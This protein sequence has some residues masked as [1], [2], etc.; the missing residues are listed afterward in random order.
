MLPQRYIKTLVVCLTLLSSSAAR[1]QVAAFSSNVTS[2]CAPLLV[3]FNNQS[4][5]ATS[6]Y[7]DFGNLGSS[8][9][10]SPQTTYTTPGTYTVTLIAYNG[11]NSNTITHT[12]TVYDNPVVSFSA[13]PTTVCPGVPV[14]FTNTSTPNTP[15][16]ATYLWDFGDG[17]QSTAQ[18]PSHGYDVGGT[19]NVTLKVT[20]S[21][22]CQ[23]TLVIPSLITVYPKPEA[24]FSA[25]VTSF[26]HAPGV[27]TFTN[28]TT[29][30]APLSY[31][32]LFGDATQSTAASP[33]A[34]SYSSGS[35]TVTLVATDG[36]GCKDSLKMVDYV[37]V[38]SNSGSIGGPTQG[39]AGQVVT[40]T[41]TTPPPVTSSLWDFGDNTTGV[42]ASVSHSYAAAGV[43]TVRLV[44]LAACP[45]TVYKTIDIH[46]KPYIDFNYSP[47]NPCP[48]PD[49]IYFN[50]L[51]VAGSS[52]KWSF[53]D[54]DTSALTNPSHIYNSA[55]PFDV[56]LVA[57]NTY[58]CTDSLTKTA[59]IYL[60]SFD[61]F[62]Y[63]SVMGGCAPVSTTFSYTNAYNNPVISQLWD[64]GDNT[65]TSTLP[66]PS[67]V[68]TNVGTYTV[69]LTVVSA[70]GCTKTTTLTIQAG[71]HSTPMFTASPLNACVHEPITF[72][73]TS[74]NATD[75]TWDFGDGF[76][77]GDS[78]PVHH[79]LYDDT[80]DV[81]LIS[82]NHGC[83][84]TL[85]RPKYILIY[86][87][88]A[89]YQIQY[90]CDTV[91]KVTITN[92]SSPYTSF[93]WSFG[94][95]TT[96]TTDTSPVH[97][98]PGL[99]TFPI[100]L[101]T[102]NSTYGC[103]D[104]L[105]TNARILNPKPDFT[106]GDTTICKGTNSHFVSSIDYQ[107]GPQSSIYNR[108]WTTNNVTQNQHDTVYYNY[109]YPNRGVYD[110]TL[111][112]M[113]EHNCLHSTTKQHYMTVAAPIAGFTAL[114]PTGCLPLTVQFTDTSVDQPGVYDT[115]R[116]WD[117]GYD[118][119]T[120][121][122]ASTS[123]TYT[124][125]GSYYVK[126]TVA[127]NLG[128][129]DS[130]VKYNFI[131]AQKPTASF[132]SPNTY[133]CK[134]DSAHFVNT[135]TGKAPLTS[136]WNFGDNT[137]STATDPVHLYADTGKYTVTLI[138]TDSTGCSDTSVMTQYI[139]VTHPH[140]SFTMNDTLGLCSPMQVNFTSTSS[141][142]TSY[143][144]DFGNT[145]TSVA[146][147]PTNLYVDPGHYTVRYIALNSHGCADTAY[148]SLTLLGYAGA[149]AYSPL[150]GCTP[151]L[152]NFTATTVNIDSMTWDFGDGNVI[153]GG[154][155]MTHVYQVPGTYL[156]LV[157]FGDTAGCHS[158]SLGLDTLRLD[159]L[160]TDFEVS[161][162]SICQ[163]GMAAF[164][165]TQATIATYKWTFDNGETS[166]AAEPAHY[167]GAP[168]TYPV[169][170]IVFTN[171]GCSDTVSKDVTVYPLP[172]IK[173]FG[174]T[175]ICEKDKALLQAEGG[176][177]Y[178]WTPTDNM[179][180]PTCDTTYVRPPRNMTFTVTGTDE[181]GCK[182]DDSVGVTL[183]ECNCIVSLPTAFTPN[184]DGK[185]DRFKV[186][187]T[188]M[189]AVHMEIYNRWGQ[190]VY[191][192]TFTDHSWDGT[193]KGVPC[194]AGTYYYFVKVK[195]IMGQEVMKKGDLELI[196]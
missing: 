125:P 51:T 185:N 119:A 195:C 68:Y 103:K 133:P 1:A 20:N 180:C 84:D 122:T 97:L 39:C 46:P 49:T 5:G 146:A 23:S 65:P 123:Y 34:H 69:T 93:I 182:N 159:G 153:K 169:S 6:Y 21:G 145:N 59:Y 154:T 158:V 137:T 88:T 35:F 99:G 94:D 194:D 91:N 66:S 2:G 82:Y 193:Y 164:R 167:Y 117:F 177:S 114:P 189:S 187:A 175:T 26:C 110:V 58:G 111:S 101:V 12:I 47:N 160:V 37:Q 92:Q 171:T 56:K 73:N 14:Q 9:Q 130:I 174:D 157:I 71:V 87:S 57:T 32:W 166:T 115:I 54:G 72:Y 50:N 95:N 176:V 172:T 134:G 128:C 142:A 8:T 113:D 138:V 112:I 135:S 148:G 85:I 179:T 10:V 136:Q 62:P 53:G 121:A 45:D 19:Y 74:L 22:G 80:F 165:D 143:R 31:L 75:F 67:H 102:Y 139:K 16:N 186:I 184:G 29:G 100:K 124:T 3:Q 70:N 98:Y 156:P 168:G 120:V 17:N 86:P 64:F 118:T 13:S 25:P 27:V 96:S 18:N 116:K 161:P 183:R 33:P 108:T 126:L 78:A 41:N 181:H 55:G 155:T 192:S 151:L 196:R 129:M 178:V 36:N 141:G 89:R 42:G 44:T 4:T 150:D 105:I 144:W 61:I 30:T 76:T 109:I 28:N 152:V 11:P 107:G 83:P 191:Y 48:Q 127:D 140:A 132:S 7:W 90:S 15:G 163:G 63:A 104:S 106:V 40:F 60:Q 77:S 52:Y 147:N 188:D 173:A 24:D 162:N 79:Y 38:Q 190:P 170:L 81:R 131:T 43:Y 149:F